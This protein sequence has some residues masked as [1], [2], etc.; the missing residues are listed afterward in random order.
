MTEKASER[1]SFRIT[2]TERKQLRELKVSQALSDHDKARALLRVGL[3][4]IAATKET[5]V[6]L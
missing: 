5:G 4:V 3:S 2:E 1:I 6:R